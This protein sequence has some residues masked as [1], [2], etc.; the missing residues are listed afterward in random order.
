M[1]IKN[2]SEL[3][4]K[5]TGF[6][7]FIAREQATE[8]QQRASQNLRAIIIELEGRQPVAVEESEKETKK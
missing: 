3:K 6:D 1:D 5:A 2:L 8:A 7:E 4:L